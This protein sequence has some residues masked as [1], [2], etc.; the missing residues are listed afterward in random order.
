M[1]NELGETKTKL[2]KMRANWSRSTALGNL[3]WRRQTWG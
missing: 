3:H 1:I 2:D